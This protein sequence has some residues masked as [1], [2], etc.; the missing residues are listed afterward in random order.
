MDFD[1]TPEEAAFRDE[2]R[3]FLDE[4][5]VPEDRRD[6]GFLKNWQRKVRE[7][8]WVGFSWPREVSGGGGSITTVRVG[9]LSTTASAITTKATRSRTRAWRTRLIDQAEAP[10]AASLIP[11]SS[12]SPSMSSNSSSY[13]SS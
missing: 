6:G 8:R 13:S 2:V 12:S 10:A 3:S 9:A 4:N 11:S 1:L 5:L 7:K